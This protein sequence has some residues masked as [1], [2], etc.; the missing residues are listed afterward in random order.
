MYDYLVFQIII[1]FILDILIGDPRWLPHPVRIIGK[2]IAF[3]EKVLRKKFASERM[4]GIFLAVIVVYGTYSLTCEL[5]SIFGSMGKI[6]EITI[7]T[8]IIF[9]SLSTR[10]LLKE[11]KVVMLELKSGNLGQARNSLSRIVGRDT[12]NLNEQQITRACVE[13]T[14]ES[15]VDGII[16]PLF[17][18]FIGG[19]ALA[20]A[21]KAVNTLDSMV[22]YKNQKYIDFGWASAKLD[23]IANYVPARIAALILPLS[24]YI[25]GKEYL[26][27]I[28]IIKRDGQNHPSPNSGI[29]EAAIAGALG[30]RL[31]GASTYQGVISYKP[32]I[33]DPANDIVLDNINHTSR[34]VF[35]AAV[36]SVAFGISIMLIGSYFAFCGNEISQII[37]EL[38]TTK[39]YYKLR[40]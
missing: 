22:G 38:L 31:G 37:K 20:M 34:I 6:W 36:L 17:Y 3:L 10:D 2:C 9:F 4:A 1:A 35:V 13:T 40:I 12:H 24:S 23:D 19:P 26:N 8:I 29:P 27:S 11:A 14:A 30:I 25:C 33:G 15:S 16:A 32:F 7:G 18:A 5:L 21:Y 39:T 28:R